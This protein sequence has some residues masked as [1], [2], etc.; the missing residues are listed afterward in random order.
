MSTYDAAT[1]VIEC[2]LSCFA[3]LNTTVKVRL[4]DLPDD[5]PTG[6]LAVCNFIC[7]WDRK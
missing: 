2:G 1:R 3:T 5:R 4:H 6:P 7:R